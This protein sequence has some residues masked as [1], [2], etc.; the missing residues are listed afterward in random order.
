VPGNKETVEK[1][2]T[3]VQIIEQEWWPIQREAC[4]KKQAAKTSQIW[5]LCFCF[6]S[7]T[8]RLKWKTWLRILTYLGGKSARK[9]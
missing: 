3:E 6:G 5:F 7:R 4:D 9:K 1:S 8:D 2:G